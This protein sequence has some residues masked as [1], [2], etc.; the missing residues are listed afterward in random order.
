VEAL[1]IEKRAAYVVIDP[2]SDYLPDVNTW[3][4]NEVRVAL[5]PFAAI[6]QRHGVAAIANM[7]LSKSGDRAATYR[8]LGS[9]AFTGLARTVFLITEDPEDQT[10]RLFLP[11]KNNLG[12]KAD[13]MAFRPMTAWIPGEPHRIKS[14]KLAWLTTEDVSLSADEA[15]QQQLGGSDRASQR[16]ETLLKQDTAEGPAR[17]TA[18]YQHAEAEHISERTI[19][20]VKKRL[21]VLARRVGPLWYW[22]PPGWPADKMKAWKPT[23]DTARERAG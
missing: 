4:D 21:R 3:R 10:R 1:I 17:V 15:L 11:V 18:I 2:L 23:P 5:K 19:D 9:V 22:S 12:P 8:I 14:Q 13:G 16:A 7:D 20:T 6:A